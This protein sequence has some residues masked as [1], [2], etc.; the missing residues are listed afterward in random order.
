MYLKLNFLCS[1]PLSKE[2]VSTGL[3]AGTRAGRPPGSRARF[4]QVPSADQ[5][6]PSQAETLAF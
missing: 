6:R 5:S 4:G 2:V 3:G 1:T